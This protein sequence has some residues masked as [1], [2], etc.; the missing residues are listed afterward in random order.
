[1]QKRLTPARVFALKGWT[2]KVD[3]KAQYFVSPTACFDDKQKWSGPY[4]SLHH[5][6]N[7]IARKLQHEFLEREK[8]LAGAK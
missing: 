2:V 1:M 8:R 5:A 6:T 7:A 3:E 4:R